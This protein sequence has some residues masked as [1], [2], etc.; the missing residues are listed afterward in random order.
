M[1][2]LRAG[3]EGIA[4]S[5]AFGIGATHTS[6]HTPSWIESFHAMVA[7]IPEVVEAYRMAGDTD[8][9]MRVVVP[10]IEAYDKVYK[11]LIEISGLSDVSSAFAMEQIKY[12][13][14]LPLKYLE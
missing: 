10:D 11:R 14:E 7:D 3:V 2:F 1:T 5:A 9:L 8:Y 4:R 12:T 13:T 6:Q